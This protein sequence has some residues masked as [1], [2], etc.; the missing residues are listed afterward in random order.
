[1]AGGS[2]QRFGRPK[3]YELIGDRR[4]L[5]RSVDVAVAAS[6]GVVLVVPADDVAVEGGVAGGA[7]RSES[8]R[9]GLVHV[10]D[11][12]AIICIHDAARP[13]ASRELYALVID[14]VI[15]GAHGA[16]PGLAVTDTIK[17]V[18]SVGVV[19]STP[20]RSTLMAVQTPQAFSAQ[21]LRLAHASGGVGTD[22]AALVEACGGVVVVVPGEIN[23]RKITHPA[24]LDWARARVAVV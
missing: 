21:A 9:A 2:G 10:P 23:N 15:A 1:M 7:N 18:N 17:V 6:S 16:V 13:F 8:V 19:V 3:Q 20:E 11:D 12:A 14:A 24:D 22:D 4:V 5:D